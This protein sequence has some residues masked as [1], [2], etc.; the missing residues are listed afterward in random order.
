MKDKF[1]Y[2]DFLAY[3]IPGTV[4]IWICIIAVKTLG[5]VSNLKTENIITDSLIFI[6]LAFVVGHFI[7]FRSKQR[8]E[9]TIKKKFWYGAFVSDQFLLKNN[10]FCSEFKR[11]K[12][13][14][15]L[16]KHFELKPEE[17]Q[18]LEEPDNSEAKK[19]S[20]DMYRTCLTFVTD[21]K[22][23]EKAT[24][25]NEYYNFFR[26]LSTT[27]FYSSV[28]LSF[29][30]IYSLACFLRNCT[31]FNISRSLIPLLLAVFSGYSTYAFQIRAKQRGELHVTE[32]FE[33]TIGYFADKNS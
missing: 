18:I 14:Q 28:I 31:D 5:L 21:R 10:K 11:Q 12:Y 29:V 4:L 22:V 25:A 9:V 33:S 26:G 6:V 19:V 20:N 15:L 30:C 32:V 3:F 24:K 23:G 2:F 17:A 1:T 7:Q 13:I 16:Q 8:T 27:C